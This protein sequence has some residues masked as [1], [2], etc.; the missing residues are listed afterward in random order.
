MPSV[1]C[2]FLAVPAE[3]ISSSIGSKWLINTSLYNKTPVEEAQARGGQ[4]YSSDC[5]Q[6]VPSSWGHHNQHHPRHLWS[7]WSKWP[8]KQCQFLLEVAWTSCETTPYLQ[9][10][11]SNGVKDPKSNED[12]TNNYDNDHHDYDLYNSFNLEGNNLDGC[13]KRVKLSGHIIVEIL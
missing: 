4:A 13:L 6:Q 8:G 11:Y 3:S 7:C 5:F 9:Q 1:L 2:G 10:S 12:D